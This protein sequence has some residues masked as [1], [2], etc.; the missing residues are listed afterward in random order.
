MP[1][2][3]ITSP[4]N[5][6]VAAAA[7]LQRSGARKRE[8]RALIEGPQI[9][10]TAVHAGTRPVEVFA[11]EVDETPEALGIDDVT[12]RVTPSVL[13][14]VAATETPRGPVA[15]ISIP[16]TRDLVAMDTLVLFEVADPGNA[17]ALLRTAGAFD[18][19][20]VTTPG[21]V[22]MWSPKVVRAAAGAHWTVR[23]THALDPVTALRDLGVVTVATVVTGGLSPDEAL[24]ADAP[25]AVMVGSEPHGL[26]DA[27][28]AT[29]DRLLTI[30]MPGGSES[31]NVAVAGSI[32]LYELDQQRSRR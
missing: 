6:R 16:P 28:S 9:L 24:A 22:D 27:V 32:A 13:Q 14:A 1:G 12:T 21:T 18:L 17:G 23:L 10:E 4:R 8:G 19:Q 26:P 3:T 30:P 29:V 5:A 11:L 2:E 31:L 20:V 25:V 7:A 15:V